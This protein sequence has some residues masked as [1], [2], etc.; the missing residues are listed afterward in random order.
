MLGELAA[1]VGAS[2]LSLLSRM[3]D[4]GAHADTEAR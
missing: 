3:A 4:R 1:P 2:G